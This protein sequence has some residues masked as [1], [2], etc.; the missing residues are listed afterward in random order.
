MGN[1]FRYWGD[2]AKALLNPF[3]KKE[4]KLFLLTCIGTDWD[5]NL[6]AHFIEHYLKLGIPAE[7][8]L[9]I[10]HSYS[11]DNMA[12][13]IQTL[14]QYGITAKL[15]WRTKYSDPVARKHLAK[16]QKEYIRNHDWVVKADLDEF[17]EY[18]DDLP[19]FLK[20]CDEKKNQLC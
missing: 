6:P 16:I 8:F 1:Y 5:V 3:G 14:S 17:H 12:K 20:N 15:L 4:S 18:P 13:G 2:R 11:K 19:T 10:L 7:N 9:I